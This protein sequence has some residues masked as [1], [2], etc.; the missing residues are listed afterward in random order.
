MTDK[1]EHAGRFGGPGS[2]HQDR[3]HPG[4]NHQP[5]GKKG[6]GDQAA[7]GPEPGEPTNP[8]RSRVSGGGGERDTHHTHT[9]RRS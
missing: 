7:A 6:G 3:E 8:S 5:T 1:N 9:D 4:K 2:S